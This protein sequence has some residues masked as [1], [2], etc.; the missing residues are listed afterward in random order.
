MPAW[1]ADFMDPKPI[2]VTSKKWVLCEDD[3][4]TYC[5]GNSSLYEIMHMKHLE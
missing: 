2:C 1:G 5:A 4:T 3:V